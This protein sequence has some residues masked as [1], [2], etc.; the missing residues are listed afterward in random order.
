MRGFPIT[1]IFLHVVGT[2]TSAR[3][4]PPSRNHEPALADGLFGPPL[5]LLPRAARLHHPHGA[6]EGLSNAE[7]S[8]H[9]FTIE[10]ITKYYVSNILCK[11]HLAYR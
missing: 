9:L 11:L 8:G 4:D 10:K 3:R 2:R 7:I 5:E 6:A 1:Y